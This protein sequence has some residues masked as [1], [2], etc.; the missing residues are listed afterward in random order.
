M[1]DNGDEMNDKDH[2]M[3]PVG[4][5]KRHLDQ[6][7]PQ[8]GEESP[9]HLVLWTDDLTTESLFRSK[10]QKNRQVESQVMVTLP[11]NLK[12]LLGPLENNELELKTFLSDLDALYNDCCQRP[13]VSRLI[14]ESQFDNQMGATKSENPSSVTASKDELP[15]DDDEPERDEM[16]KTRLIKV[17]STSIKLSNVVDTMTVVDITSSRSR[18]LTLLMWL[19]KDNNPY[20]EDLVPGL[21]ININIKTLALGVIDAWTELGLWHLEHIFLIYRPLFIQLLKTLSVDRHG[22]AMKILSKLLTNLRATDDVP[23]DHDATPSPPDSVY[24]KF[25]MKIINKPFTDTFTWIG[26]WS[27]Y[28]DDGAFG[29]VHDTIEMTLQQI[30]FCIDKAMA[31]PTGNHSIDDLLDLSYQ[32]TLIFMPF[33]HHDGEDILHQDISKP[34]FQWLVKLLARVVSIEPPYAGPLPNDVTNGGVLSMSDMTRVFP[35]STLFDPNCGRDGVQGQQHKD[36][37]AKHS[38]F[39]HVFRVIAELVR[40]TSLELDKYIAYR[41]KHQEIL[42]QLPSDARVRY[43]HEERSDWALSRSNEINSGVLCLRDILFEI[44]KSILVGTQ[45]LNGESEEYVTAARHAV[46]DCLK[47]GTYTGKFVKVDGLAK[48]LQSPAANNQ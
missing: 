34:I 4:P 45:E 27:L 41:S 10:K 21:S 46:L 44:V 8:N 24:S 11:P 17:L 5:V 18:L 6:S 3:R 40:V 15:T 25:N 16:I 23:L 13:V 42:Q 2:K 22:Y 7:H 43:Y 39:T 30:D 33:V 12:E 28:R 29:F 47:L 20:L 48:F 26:R 36:C 32:F 35:S 38:F 9:T 31:D 19:M 14:S 37:S 1:D